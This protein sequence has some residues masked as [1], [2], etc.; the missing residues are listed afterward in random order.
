MCVNCESTPKSEYISAEFR[1][2]V[3][4]YCYPKYRDIDIDRSIYIFI[5]ITNNNNKQTDTYDKYKE[6]NLD[7]PI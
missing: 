5:Q 2:S 1:D 7:T 4:I 3:N 6:S